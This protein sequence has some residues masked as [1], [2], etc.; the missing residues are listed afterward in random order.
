MSIRYTLAIVLLMLR[1]SCFLHAGESVAGASESMP[2]IYKKSMLV[3]RTKDG[4]AA[5]VFEKP[6]ANGVTYRYRLLAKGKTKE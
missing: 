3:V 2:V 6:I 4:V 5:V 1:F